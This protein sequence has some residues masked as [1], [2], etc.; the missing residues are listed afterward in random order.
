MATLKKFPT[1]LIVVTLLSLVASVAMATSGQPML[2]TSVADGNEYAERLL[3][4]EVNGSA[5]LVAQ[6]LKMANRIQTVSVNEAVE[7]LRQTETR[8]CP[9]GT[10][11]L[12]SVLPNGQ[13]GMVS[14]PYR[15]N[16]FCLWDR[17]T[18]TVVAS[19]GCGNIDLE[20]AQD[21]FAVPAR[22]QEDEVFFAS[23][24]PVQTEHVSAL[25]SQRGGDTV[26]YDQGMSTGT[27]VGL[28]VLGLGL[29][30]AIHESD[31][32][33][34]VVN[35]NGT[36]AG[37][38]FSVNGNNNATCGS[39]VTAPQ[40]VVCNPP[41]QMVNGVCSAPTQCSGGQILV[42]NTCQCPAG[43]QVINGVCQ[44]PV[45]YCP[46]GSVRPANGQCPVVCSGGQVPYG[47]TCQ[48]PTGT[49]LINGMCR[50]PPQQCTGGQILV[51]D[52]CQCPS[53]Q[54][55]IHGFCQVP[56]P[57]CRLDQIAVGLT[58]QCPV[59]QQEIG[60]RCQTILVCT[61]GQVPFSGVC[62]CPVGQ[63]LFAG[64]CRVPL[65]QCPQ[66]Q[67]FIGGICQGPSQQTCPQGEELFAGVCRIPLP[68]GG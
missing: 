40:P 17:N 52:Y 53:G 61:G 18:G 15:D 39:V 34:T 25:S 28:G 26:V 35:N 12:S 8:P 16:E 30:Y 48:C 37:A 45:Q 36:C 47:N 58:C 42:G 13:L 67:Q 32:P 50:V 56:P 57:V 6:A 27:K 55:F 10:R 11:K 14:R 2:K 29:A 20:R 31:K 54:Q 3:A 43:Q 60:G 19:A 4:R 24:A 59:G 65:P 23:A 62:Q 44:N 33:R 1:S 63:E 22:A 68:G 7:Y 51:G 5:I 46:D 66:G 64:V 41:S 49:I 38:N 21:A 9:A